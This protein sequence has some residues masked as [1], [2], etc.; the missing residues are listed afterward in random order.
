MALLQL[1]GYVNILAFFLDRGNRVKIRQPTLKGAAIKTYLVVPDLH[2]PYQCPKY[3]RLLIKV[4][5]EVRP[6]GIVQLGDALDFFQLSTY[7]KDPARRN[8]I[9]DDIADWNLVLSEWCRYLPRNGE[10]HLLCGNHE[11]R[12]VRYIARSA[13]DL[14]EIVRPL[15]ELLKIKER[16]A[17]GSIKFKWHPYTKWS[18]CR[19]GDCVLL[20]GFYFSTHT[21]ATNLA[22][23][24][25]N[26]ISGHTHR[27]QYVTDG[28]HYAASLGHGSDEAITAHQPTPTGWTQALGLLHVDNDGTTSLDII[29][30]KDGRCVINGKVIRA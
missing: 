1:N 6:F 8:T 22:K 23:Y 29:T 14:H 11:Y 13:R 24:R 19:I 9:G 3:M 17:A 26:T 25:C 18:S 16:N 27:V 15:P 2:L 7:D 21:A 30:V 5:K 12:A 20:H 10:I 4:L 28:V